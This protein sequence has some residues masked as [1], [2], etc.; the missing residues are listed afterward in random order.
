M[1]KRRMDPEDKDAVWEGPAA[2]YACPESFT[3]TIDGGTKPANQALREYNRRHGLVDRA[4]KK[5]R[6]DDADLADDPDDEN[7]GDPGD[8]DQDGGRTPER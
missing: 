6:A 1:T 2:E 8:N 3:I 7:R 5:P 4:A